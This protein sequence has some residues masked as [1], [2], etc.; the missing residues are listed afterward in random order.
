MPYI[1]ARWKIIDQPCWSLYQQRGHLVCRYVSTDLC[2]ILWYLSRQL[3]WFCKAFSTHDSSL[4]YDVHKSWQI[5]TGT[6]QYMWLG[7][8]PQETQNICLSPLLQLR[9]WLKEPLNILEILSHREGA[10]KMARSK[11]GDTG[12]V[13]LSFIDATTNCQAM[14]LIL[15]CPVGKMTLSKVPP[16]DRTGK[17]Q[18]DPQPSYLP[19]PKWD[20]K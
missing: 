12:K 4:S 10:Q 13:L 6:Y 17:K 2:P 18:T 16:L 5:C 15:S 3:H 1:Q 19:L 11:C 7:S 20:A 14:L 8:C 9:A